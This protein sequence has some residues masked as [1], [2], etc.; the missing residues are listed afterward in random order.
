IDDSKKA[1]DAKPEKKK[2][3]EPSPQSSQRSAQ[4]RPQGG[5]EA[6][7]KEKSADGET[8]SPAVRRVVD[9]EHLDPAKISGTGPGGRITKADALAAA[10]NHGPVGDA[11]SVSGKQTASRTEDRAAAAAPSAGGQSADGRFV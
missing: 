9:E 6:K 2:E 7:T 5:G 11:V 1:P 8:L 3:A 10:Q 4:S